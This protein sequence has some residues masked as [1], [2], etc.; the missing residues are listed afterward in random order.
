MSIR[1]VVPSVVLS[2]IPQILALSL[3]NV[4]RI[5]VRFEVGLQMRLIGTLQV[6]CFR[7]VWADVLWCPVSF[8]LWEKVLGTLEADF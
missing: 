6:E 4:T 1:I 5:A 3:A 7:T 2:E 8:G